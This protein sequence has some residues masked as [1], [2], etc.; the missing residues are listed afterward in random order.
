M[1]HF[2]DRHRQPV[3]SI[4]KTARF[5]SVPSSSGG[6]PPG[7][8]KLDCTMPVNKSS[9]VLASRLT[10]SASAP[11]FSFRRESRIHKDEFL[12]G[13]S[14]MYGRDMSSLGPGQYRI[15]KTGTRTYKQAAP[16]YSI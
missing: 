1:D 2:S 9:E 5:P 12:K 10:R 11:K 8:Y 6:L 7:H 13:I 3:Y 4:T 14:P 16:S 15:P